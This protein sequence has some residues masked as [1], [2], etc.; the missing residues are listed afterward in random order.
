[1]LVSAPAGSDPEAVENAARAFAAETFGANWDYVMARHDDTSNPHV[2]IV[3]ET[4]GMDGARFTVEPS[5]IQPLRERF[6][7][8]CRDEGLDLTATPRAVRA[9]V[10]RGESIGVV[11]LREEGAVPERD[12]RPQAEADAQRGRSA[13]QRLIAREAAVNRVLAAELRKT[14]RVEDARAA[15]GLDGLADRADALLDREIEGDDEDSQSAT[16]QPEEPPLAASADDDARR[17]ELSGLDHLAALERLAALR[18]RKYD[19]LRSQFSELP[20]K[21]RSDAL[22]SLRKYERDMDAFHAEAEALHRSFQAPPGQPEQTRDHDPPEDTSP[23]LE[24]Q[25]HKDRR[26]DDRDDDR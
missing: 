4:R 18:K 5:D 2:H 17:A 22:D 21:A 10:D 15:L 8:A 13:E 25:H 14:G 24:N 3:A 20:G 6:A 16:H 12:A 1:M 23:T 9:V 19:A 7:E 26:D 11:K